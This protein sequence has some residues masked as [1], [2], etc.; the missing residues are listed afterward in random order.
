MDL[1]GAAGLTKSFVSQ[2]ERGRNSPSIGT[3]RSIVGAPDVPMFYFFQAEQNGN[4][5]VRAKERRIVKFA[6]GRLY[7]EFLTPDLQR[8]IEMIEVRLK[9]G[10][11]AGDI[12]RTHEGEETVVVLEGT[13][14][15]EVSGVPYRLDKGDS[16]CTGSSQ[17]HRVSNAGSEQAVRSAAISPPSFVAP[18]Y[19]G[20]FALRAA[21]SPSTWTPSAPTCGRC[22]ATFR[23]AAAS[24]RRSR[25]MP[26]ATVWRR[27]RARP[28]EAGAVG[29]AVA[30][31]EEA[32]ALRDSGRTGRI[33]VMGPLYGVD[34]CLELAARDVEFAVVAEDMVSMLRALRGTGVSAMAHLKVDSGMNRQGLLPRQV[35]WFLDAVRGL[36]EVR[37]RGVMTHFACAPEDPVSVEEQLRRFLPCVD[38][39]RAEWREA[40]AHAANSAATVLYPASHLSF[41]RCGIAVYGMSPFQAVAEEEGLKPALSWTSLVALVKDVPAGEGVGYSHT[42]RAPSARKIGLVPVGYADGVFRALGNRGEV[43]IGGRRYPM[44]G[45]VS[46]D[47]FGIDLGEESTVRPGDTVTLIGRDG[48]E[49]ITAEDLAARVGTINYEITCAIDLAR[50]ERRFVGAVG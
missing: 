7:Y 50:A 25:P 38:R 13:L 41:V 3:L 37:V 17:P 21:S 44:V 14:E 46:M 1:E 36:P 2:V 31:A 28:L 8:S 32:V 45:R 39:V 30:T 15:V 12:A 11:C 27:W 4:P 35:E 47:S 49:R 24:S 33:L 18:R 29:M 22:A 5:V 19:P 10:Q 23:P 6:G 43:L 48:P 40:E 26:T 20:C 34:Q 42:Y 9:A 16:I